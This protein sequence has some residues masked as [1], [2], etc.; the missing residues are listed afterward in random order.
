[1]DENG[2]HEMNTQ[3]EGKNRRS[4]KHCRTVNYGVKLLASALVF[5]TVAGS[6]MVGVNVASSKAGITGSSGAS[7]TT[8]STADG[9]ASSALYKNS[10]SSGS[11]VSYSGSASSDSSD[12]QSQKSVSEIAKDAMPSVVSI[13]NMIEYQNNGFSIF[14]NDGQTAEAAASGS[15]II[16]GKNDD[17]LLIVT[18]NH[19]V[20]DSSSLS[21][22]FVNGTSVNAEIKGTDSDADLAVIAVKLSDMDSDTLNAIKIAEFGDSDSVE[23][24]DQVVAIGNALGYGQSV[25]TGIISAKN[26]DVDTSEG[27]T[28]T[29][30]LQTDAAINPGNSGGALLNMKGQVIGIN[31]AKYSSTDVEGMGY[32]IPSKKAQTVISTLSSKKTRSVVDEDKQGYLGIQ[33]KTV[34]ADVASAYNM[35][36]G[37]YIYKIMDNSAAASGLQEKDII[38]KFDDQSVSSSDELTTLLKKYES[39]ETV[40]VTVQRMNAEGQYKEQTVSVTLGSKPETSKKTDGTDDSTSNQADNNGSESSGNS[41]HSGNDSGSGNFPDIEQWLQGALGGYQR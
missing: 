5:G 32:S 13:T 1:M 15:G 18:N 24:G 28:E 39:G 9:S 41:D 31:V 38:T 34:S 19:V 37:V 10:S 26:R 30:L 21:V 8:D 17:E 22:Q 16:V 14:G 25:T 36:Q 3:N 2:I 29:G 23:V 6:A 33:A 12:N 40:N 7:S 11:S 35:P 20:S 4:R 27:T